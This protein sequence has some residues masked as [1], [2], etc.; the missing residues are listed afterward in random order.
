MA[1]LKRLLL[2]DDD[3]ALDAAVQNAV[4]AVLQGA[5]G[6]VTACKVLARTVGQMQPKEAFEST[7]RLIAR[8]RADPEGQEGMSAFLERR[9]PS[10]VATSGESE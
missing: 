2:V 9:R 10:W 5:P 8:L 6:A 4:E 3:E 1:I 7:S